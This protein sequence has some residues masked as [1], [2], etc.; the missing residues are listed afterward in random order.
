M[1]PKEYRISK[2]EQ[3]SKKNILLEVR[4]RF[5]YLPGQYIPVYVPFLGVASFPICSYDKKML[6][7]LV[8]TDSKIGKELTKYKERSKIFIYKPFGR[9]LDVKKFE[10]KHAV[11]ILNRTGLP[12]ARALVQYLESKK[13]KINDIIIYT[14]FNKPANMFFVKDIKRWSQKHNVF[15]TSLETGKQWYGHLGSIITLLRKV[16][17]PASSTIAVLAGEKTTKQIIEFLLEKKYDKKMIQMLVNSKLSWHNKRSGQCLI[18][19]TY[20]CVDGPVIPYT[21][22]ERLML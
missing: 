4:G 21:E 16:S 11:I 8:N 3:V 22:Y 20:L 10:E 18:K 7:F 2:R 19:D 5:S 15:T 12:I 1:I 17:I 6:Q 13:Q 14:G 9:G